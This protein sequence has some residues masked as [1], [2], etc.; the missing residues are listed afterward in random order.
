[1]SFFAFKTIYGTHAV[2]DQDA[3]DQLFTT[4]EN[5]GLDF[6]NRYQEILDVL[7]RHA[8]FLEDTKPHIFTIVVQGQSM[9][10][11]PRFISLGEV[12][13]NNAGLVHLVRQYQS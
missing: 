11:Y 5:K 2:T 6:V 3:L 9:K 12:Y 4:G 1:M 7:I 10:K 8:C 13:R